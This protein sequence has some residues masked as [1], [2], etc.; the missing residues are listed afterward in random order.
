VIFVAF[1]VF[2]PVLVCCAKKNLATLLWSRTDLKRASEDVR[3][4]ALEPGEQRQVGVAEV[5]LA[6]QVGELREK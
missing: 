2:S 6:E 1:S 4:N 3:R 5:G